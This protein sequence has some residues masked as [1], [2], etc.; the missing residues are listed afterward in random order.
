V[1]NTNTFDLI[2]IGSGSGLDV[3]NAVHQDGLKVA[4]IEKDKMGGTCLNRGCV[5]SKLLIHSADISEIIKSAHLFG[6]K[7][8][9]FSI[10]FESIVNRVN[11]ITDSQSDK[12]K[13]AF[14]DS[15]NPKLFSKE[16]RFIG[17][18][19]IS[20]DKDQN[21]SAEKILIASGTRPRIP[22]IKGLEG[23]GYITSD[24]ALRLRK[25]PKV[26]TIIGGG[27]IACELAHFFGALGTKINIVQ[28][29]DVLIPSEDEEISQR[30]TDIFSKKYNVYLGCEAEFVSKKHRNGDGDGAADSDSYGTS[31][32]HNDDDDVDDRSIFH[33]LAK[34]S[35][36]KSIEFLSDQL[37]IAAGRIP[38]SDTL[39][40]EQTGVKVNKRGFIIT[41]RYL[42]TSVNGIFALGD[43][44]GRYLFKHN[45]N[46][47][48]QYAYNNIMHP[49][50][51]IPVN[52]AAMP[53]AIF[54]SPQVA[55]VGFTEQELKEGE[56]RGDNSI[57]YVK[58]VYPYINTAMG[59]ALEDKD[60]FV[61]FIV[62]KK[63]RKILGCHIIGSQASILIHEVL[64]AMKSNEGLDTIDSI[65][66]VVHIH[67]ALSEVI[68]R[69]AHDIQ[70]K[71]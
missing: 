23:S 46:H 70:R 56:E 16:C 3:A 26:L 48:A 49:D 19:T 9:G 63:D 65:T 21:I 38:N 22:K 20:T 43:A 14:A 36:G 11:D 2:V 13:N 28:K 12:I 58:S 32:N 15:Q 50:R 33:V 4:V 62:R 64:V 6:L 8:N 67:P 39:D 27:Y 17:Q 18:K 66:R 34:D 42:E 54:S 25:Q 53:H 47:E 68:I 10:D 45:A 37:L 35:S 44:I 40:L 61:K 5:P 55:G 31:I 30:F 69:A 1:S 71:M 7:V 60:G 52:Y 59:L 57:D 24:E 41:D 51:K 29:A